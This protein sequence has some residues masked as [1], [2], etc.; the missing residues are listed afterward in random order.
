MDSYTESP[1]S[2]IGFILWKRWRYLWPE[3]ADILGLASA[4]H[5]LAGTGDA[6]GERRNNLVE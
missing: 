5:D 3:N 4:D 6:Q 1:I 2:D